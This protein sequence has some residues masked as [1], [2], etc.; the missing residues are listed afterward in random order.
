M[1]IVTKDS[2]VRYGNKRFALISAALIA[3]APLVQ[4]W[5]AVNHLPEMLI[6]MFI[7]W[8]SL[9]NLLKKHSAW[10][11]FGFIL[12]I[13]WA[14]CSFIIT[15]YPAW[16]IPLVYLILVVSIATGAFIDQ[17]RII[18]KSSTILIIAIIMVTGLLV[19]PIQLSS[20]ALTAQPLAEQ[21]KAIDFRKKGKWIVDG[22]DSARI[23]QL[24]IA[25]GI[26]TVNT[27]SVTPNRDLWKVLDPDGKL[28]HV[29]NRYAN[30]EVEIV[31][32]REPE[33]LASVGAY[34]DTIKLRLTIEDLSK[35]GVTD[36]LS[37][38]D[39]SLLVD[40]HHRFI[41]VGVE[42]SG[43]QAYELQNS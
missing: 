36:V 7:A 40:E 27:V 18:Q 4:W 12:I 23:P 2:Q 6:A 5:F 41:P 42:V 9:D 25:N 35:L 14:A 38:R 16:Q 33:N 30:I 15:L 32:K 8:I 31:E 17:N 24:L 43:R 37:S 34:Q 22:D 21:V 20:K 1:L 13:A 10:E 26:T 3:F 11:R 19:N 29:Y 28:D 39:L